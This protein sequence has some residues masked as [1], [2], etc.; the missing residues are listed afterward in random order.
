MP[1]YGAE[2]AWFRLQVLPQGWLNGLWTPREWLVSGLVYIALSLCA[3]GLGFVRFSR[4]D[5]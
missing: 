5:L 4:R 2:R 3:V 1:A